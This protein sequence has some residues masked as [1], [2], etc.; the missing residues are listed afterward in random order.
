M[1]APHSHGVWCT[2]HKAHSWGDTYLYLVFSVQQQF[3]L[4]N[5]NNELDTIL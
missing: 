5:G 4:H 1:N 2:T 3:A